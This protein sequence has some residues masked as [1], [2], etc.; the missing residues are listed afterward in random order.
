MTSNQSYGIDLSTL[1][2]PKILEENNRNELD[3]RNFPG[4]ARVFV[5]KGGLIRAGERAW[6]V[7]TGAG[8]N[9]VPVTLKLMDGDLIS[10]D[11]E[12]NG[13]TRSIPRARLLEFPHNAL[14]TIT[15]KVS[16]C[17]N[18]CDNELIVYPEQTC[19]LTLVGL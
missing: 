16:T 5:E 13:L 14:L 7:V 15:L 11:D 8:K 6:L 4:D 12:K 9:G 3:L 18:S 19:T 17:H 10:I 1:I 2:A